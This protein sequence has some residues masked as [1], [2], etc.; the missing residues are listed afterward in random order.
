MRELL[1]IR[2]SE[3]SKINDAS[4]IFK[5]I[6]KIRIDY[7]QENFLLFCLNA[8][9]NIIKVI[10]LFKGGIDV[11]AISLITLFKSAIKYNAY[12]II[13]AH[14]HPS[15]LKPSSEDLDLIKRVKDAGGILDINLLD[16]IIFNRKEFY[17]VV[18]V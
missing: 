8:R 15:G 16:S 10:N 3:Y 11:C 1:I 9:C 12:N 13:I 18:E 7:N 4:D 14:N 17:R 2:E 5:R 6:E